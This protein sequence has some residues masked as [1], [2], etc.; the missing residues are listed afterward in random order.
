MTANISVA[1]ALKSRLLFANFFHGSSWSLWRAVLK[2]A[3]GEPLTADELQAFRSVADRD[4]PTKRVKELVCVVGRGGGKDAIASFIATLAAVTFEPKGKLRPG[5]RASVFC[6]GCDTQ[7]AA[8]AHRYV[9]GYFE[10]VPAFAK[11]VDAINTETIVLNN[12]VTIETRANSYRSVRGRS[13][14]CAILDEISFYRSENSANPDFELY[15]AL[16]PSLARVTGSMMVLISSA[17]KRSG[18]LYQ[19]YKEHFG[20]DDADTLVV[21][22]TT[23]QFNPTFDQSEIDKALASDPALYGAEYLS[24]WRDDISSFI[25]RELVEAS[26]GRGVRVRAPQRGVHYTSFCDPSGGS[27]DSFTCG[28]AHREGDTAVLDALIEI[29]APFNP[30]HRDQRYC[31]CFEQLWHLQND[32]RQI[33]SPVGGRCL[34][35]Q[36]NQ[37]G[38]QRA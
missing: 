12:G 13:I 18:L 20:K 37:A 5:E 34:C 10:Q 31:N 19:K 16:R 14:L 1:N 2:A 27:R 33:R 22:G 15:G 3:N 11:M 26:I 24:E 23:R 8:I 38:A 32:Q 9:A 7:Q 25:P 35:P 28:I 6:I 30:A 29:A 4:P 17:H 36:R 21:R